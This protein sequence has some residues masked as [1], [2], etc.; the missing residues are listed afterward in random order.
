[1]AVHLTEHIARHVAMTRDQIFATASGWS[2]RTLTTRIPQLTRSGALE[3]ARAGR[4]GPMAYWVSESTRARLQ[5]ENRRHYRSASHE[6]FIAGGLQHALDTNTAAIAIAGQM[7]E[8]L[9]E[10]EY[11]LPSAPKRRLTPDAIL[12]ANWEGRPFRA[13]VEL[14]NGTERESAIAGKIA[15]Y[16]A[17]AATP[18]ARAEF[19]PI[20]GAPL[21]GFPRL[22]W[23]V[24]KALGGSKAED[25][26]HALIAATTRIA[27]DRLWVMAT[28]LP[29]LQSNTDPMAPLYLDAA[30]RRSTVLGRTV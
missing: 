10:T 14:D 22:I 3:R 11:S 9:W 27:G 28:T 30:G 7:P 20:P 6:A 19:P 2:E 8:F 23:V 29:E 5:R 25:R 1:M 21:D 4:N 18:E 26:A 17:Y 15:A 24:G 12:T 13:F 16:L